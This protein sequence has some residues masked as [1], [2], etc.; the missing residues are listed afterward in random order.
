[1]HI[2]AKTRE[3]PGDHCQNISS[4]LKHYGTKNPFAGKFP[5]RHEQVQ[6]LFNINSEAAFFKGMNT[7]EFTGSVQQTSFETEDKLPE[8]LTS[9]SN[10]ASINFSDRE[11]KNEC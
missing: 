9:L 11:L 8:P 10:P 2:R 5:L 3:L 1:M 4:T 6:N 7:E